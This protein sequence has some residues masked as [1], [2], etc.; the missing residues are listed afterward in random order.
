MKLGPDDEIEVFL[1]TFER[2]AE[3]TWWPQDKGDFIL[4][5]YLTGEAQA[6]L[7]TSD[8]AK[9]MDYDKVIAA[10][11]EQLEWG[12]LKKN[13]P[14]TECDVGWETA[15]QA[16]VVGICPLAWT[17]LIELGKTHLVALV[18]ICS[19]ISMIRSHLLLVMLLVLHIA[20]IEC[21]HRH[22]N[23][24]LVA[25]LQET[26]ELA[27]SAKEA[28]DPDT[29]HAL[30]SND[31]PTNDGQADLRDWWL[32]DLQVR[33][34]Q[35]WDEALV[36]LCQWV[37]ECLTVIHGDTCLNLEKV[38]YLQKRCY[39]VVNQLHTFPVE[40]QV[41]ISWSVMVQ[42]HG[43]PWQGP[44]QIMKVLGL[45]SYEVYPPDVAPDHHY[46]RESG[47]GAGETHAAKPVGPSSQRSGRNAAAGHHR[48]L[49]ETGERKYYPIAGMH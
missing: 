10:I 42:P 22:I 49:K 9:V 33:D 18:N 1:E 28:L 15:M 12:H 11:L 36:G 14:F 46:P 6:M 23:R 20:T 3:A 37:T 45:L 38:H 43:D 29:P 16:M 32:W 4:G 25:T 31:A 5:P 44:Y 2:V 13:C 27:S 48:V 41:L 35:E 34:A 7:K 17:L 19:S 30:S 21:F 39:D 47:T 24:C 8:K 40:A 26:H